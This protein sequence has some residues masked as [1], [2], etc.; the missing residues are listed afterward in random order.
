M[1]PLVAHCHLS[2]GQWHRRAGD[3][4]RAEEHMAIARALYRE[5]GVTLWLAQVEAE[6]PVRA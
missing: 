5:M 2:L 6:Q 4:A 1:Q 3:R